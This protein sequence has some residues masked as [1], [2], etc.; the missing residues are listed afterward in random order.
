M[1][2]GK[3]RS[4]SK[5]KQFILEI[6]DLYRLFPCLW[7][8]KS[9]DYH[10]RY[11]K[12][13]AYQTLLC[14][15]REMFPNATKDDVKK[16]I[17]SLRTNYRKE[18]KRHLESK[19]TASS[20][21]DVYQPTSWYYNKMYFLQDLDYKESE[22]DSHS[23]ETVFVHSPERET[24]SFSPK[25][26]ENAIQDFTC[27]GVEDFLSGSKTN[28]TPESI[29]TILNRKNDDEPTTATKHLRQKPDQYENWAL[30]CAAD[31]KKMEPIQQILAKNAISTILMDGQLGL[32]RHHSVKIN[33]HTTSVVSSSFAAS[34]RY[35]PDCC[36]SLETQL[37]H[38]LQTNNSHVKNE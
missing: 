12:N 9:K 26:D 17:N 10:V 14:K 34:E 4:I 8:T 36:S 7:N 29:A 11:K 25:E 19:K 21:N 6:I 33:N 18:L 27:I 22:A 24:E 5:E 37:P 15:Y 31:L 2:A 28:T 23:L 38:H 35:T 13:A 1:H 30:S 16:K 20:R 3:I 32:L